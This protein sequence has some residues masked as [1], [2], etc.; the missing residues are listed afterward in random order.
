MLLDDPAVLVF[1]E[2]LVDRQFL[3]FL[4]CPE[5]QHQLNPEGLEHPVFLEALAYLVRLLLSNPERHEHPD[6]LGPP[7]YPD[8][9]AIPVS[10]VSLGLLGFLGCL[11]FLEG[12]EVLEHLKYLVVLGV[13]LVYTSP[14]EH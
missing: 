11:V 4:A 6:F 5:H 8:F 9:L 14:V 1:L 7:G 10:P 12:L 13:L 3:G 2:V